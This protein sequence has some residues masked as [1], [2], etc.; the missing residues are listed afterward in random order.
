MFA[1]AG[2]IASEGIV[3]WLQDNRA[4]RWSIDLLFGIS[5]IG[6]LFSSIVKNKWFEDCAGSG[7]GKLSCCRL[8]ET[9][10]SKEINDCSIPRNASLRIRD[11]LKLETESYH[12]A[13]RLVATLDCVIRSRV[14]STKTLSCCSRNGQLGWLRKER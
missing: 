14:S 10:L 6:R 3:T 9:G 8:S 2:T 5:Q 4:M 7:F 13:L 1:F 11:R 12:E